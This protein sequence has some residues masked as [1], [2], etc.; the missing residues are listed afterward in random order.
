MPKA[1]SSRVK[2]N[3]KAPKSSIKRTT[4]IDDIFS[5]AKGKGKPSDKAAGKDTSS[6]TST[7]HTP[8]GQ[9]PTV[10]KRERK[11]KSKLLLLASGE[12]SPAS[13]K[14]PADDAEGASGN[15]GQRRR[16][17]PGAPASAPEVVVDPSTKI[18]A[19][20]RKLNQKL[21]I[22]KDTDTQQLTEEDLG[23]V[24]SRGT[25]PRRRT[26][27]GF[28]IYKED[29]LGI[30]GKGGGEL[31]ILGKTLRFVLSTATVAI[32]TNNL[33]I[34]FAGKTLSM[35]SGYSTGFRITVQGR[36]TVVEHET[37]KVG[38]DN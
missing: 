2:T 32:D 23:F 6:A 37:E 18:E 4:E 33:L 11:Q 27:E 31:P 34:S 8:H 25:G 26:E 10:S 28:F 30:T 16:Q 36:S 19:K 29:E 1:E 3:L 17:S 13:G 7:S 14:P 15:L 38:D 9:S 20:A 35:D 5:T 12:P 22:R 21:K 24:D